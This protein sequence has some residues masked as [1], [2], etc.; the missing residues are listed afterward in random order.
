MISLSVA[1]EHI[2]SWVIYRSEHGQPEDG[3]IVSVNDRYVM[4]RYTRGGGTKATDPRSL[5]W[6]FDL[7]ARADAPQR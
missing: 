7:E 5:S 6:P 1:A 4:V 2:G 3:R